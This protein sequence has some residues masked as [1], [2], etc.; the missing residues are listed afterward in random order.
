MSTSSSNDFVICKPPTLPTIIGASVFLAGSIEMGTAIDWQS[1]VTAALRH[2]P[3]T[4][5][6]PRRDDWDKSWTQDISNPHFREQVDWEMN[7]LQKADIIALFFQPGTMSPISLL[8]LGLHASD[9][10]LVVCCP[11]GFWRRGNVQMVCHTYKIPLFE[12]PE[13]LKEAVKQRLEDV[14]K[15]RRVFERKLDV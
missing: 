2:L 14:I 12:T 7:H 5:L 13:E 15:Q 11:E 6:N 9:G 3:V 1:D 4:V 8:E 10:K